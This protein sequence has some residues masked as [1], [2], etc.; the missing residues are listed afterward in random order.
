ML[1]LVKERKNANA[2]VPIVGASG[3]ARARPI[4]TVYFTHT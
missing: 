4:A 1:T 2:I 3:K